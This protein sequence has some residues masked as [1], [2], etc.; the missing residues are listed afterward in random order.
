M[1]YLRVTQT[2]FD[3]AKAEEYV[4][5]HRGVMEALRRQPGFQ[6]IHAGIDRE[7]GTGITI[8]TFDTREHANLDRQQLGDVVRQMQALAQ[9]APA[10]IY[11]VEA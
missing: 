8:S 3:P 5:L 9:V 7:G 11:Q 4:R 1:P 2:T 10:V 6:H